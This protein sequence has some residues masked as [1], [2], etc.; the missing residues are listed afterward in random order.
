MFRP[1]LAIRR[2]SSESMMVVLYRIDVVMSRHNYINPIKHYHHTFG[3]IPD[4]GRNRPKHVVAIIFIKHLYNINCCVFDWYL[5]LLFTEAV[6]TNSSIKWHLISLSVSV[7]ADRS[8]WSRGLSRRSETA[9]LP[10]LPVR[11]P[12]V[13]WMFFSCV[14]CVSCR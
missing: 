3:W 2:Y 1:I 7:S 12:L 9:C 6:F 5:H 10:G 14:Y 4:D 13:A 11:I 8:R